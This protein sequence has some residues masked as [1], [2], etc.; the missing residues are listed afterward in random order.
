M[1]FARQASI[2][3]AFGLCLFNGTPAQVRDQPRPVN[4]D[5]GRLP[6]KEPELNGKVLSQW[7]K[8][9]R[10]QDPGVRASAMQ[11]V[12][13]FGAAGRKAS[14]A[15][16]SE[17][18]DRDPALRANAAVALSAVGIEPEDVQSGMTGLCR[19]LSDPQ[20]IVR[21]RAAMTLGSFGPQARDGIPNLIAALKDPSASWEVRKAVALALGLAGV[22]RENGPNPRCIR[23]LAEALRDPAASVRLEAVTGLVAL[24]KPTV[25]AERQWVIRALTRDGLNDRDKTVGLWARV[26]LMR[27][28]KVTEP[29][30]Q[31][32]G[33]F[34]KN[35]D[36]T[37]RIQ[38]V[39]A[40]GTLGAEAESCVPQLVEALEDPDPRVIVM[41]ASALKR[42]GKAARPSVP[43]LEKL[44]ANK[45]DVIRQ[46]AQDAIE[47]IMGK[48]T[49][50]KN[51]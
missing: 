13:L 42:M 20:Q 40:L 5:K 37:L 34:L 48:P 36:V 4:S 3:V 44:A 12:S 27:M 10:D 47:S 15:L 1:Q 19:L 33:N 9:I 8:E 49:K 6:V 39:R 14:H 23:S 16:V 29:H 30:L 18:A 51:P 11:A 22:D 24:G 7:I 28:E 25:P 31:A 38:A 45:N 17:L 41:A 43:D 32:V 35:S 21:F 2:S 46:V 50:A 26:A